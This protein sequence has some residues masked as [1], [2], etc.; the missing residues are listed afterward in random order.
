MLQAIDVTDPLD[1]QAL[2]AYPAASAGSSVVIGRLIY[3]VDGAAGLLVLR[4]PAAA[5]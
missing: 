3:V 2:T 5:P 4:L 1:P